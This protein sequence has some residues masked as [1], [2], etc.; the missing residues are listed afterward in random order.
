MK[1]IQA[2]ISR[3]KLG[4]ARMR[5]KPERAERKISLNLMV[6]G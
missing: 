1:A 6:Q 5:R 4:K 3:L 2:I